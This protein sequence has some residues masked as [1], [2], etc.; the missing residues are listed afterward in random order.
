MLKEIAGS[1]SI[2]LERPFSPYP[3]Q[4]L[5]LNGYYHT[6]FNRGRVPFSTW[7]TAVL[8]SNLQSSSEGRGN[9]GFAIFSP[10]FLNSEGRLLFSE[11]SVIPNCQSQNGFPLKDISEV[12]SVFN[13]EDD[14]DIE[15]V[16]G[17]FPLDEY[18]KAVDRAKE[19]LSYNHLLGMQYSKVHIFTWFCMIVK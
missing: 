6:L 5:Q 12:V 13:E 17:S 16:Y 14:Q 2:V 10:K 18:I 1:L 8:S 7:N 15:W 4:Q 3:I 19:E 9:S 11:K